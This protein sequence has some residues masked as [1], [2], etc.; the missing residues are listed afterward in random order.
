MKRSSSFSLIQ[1][2]KITIEVTSL[3]FQVELEWFL[4]IDYY[5]DLFFFFFFFWV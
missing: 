1:K 2:N 4:L 3:S 5:W